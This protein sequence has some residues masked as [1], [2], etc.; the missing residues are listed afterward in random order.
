MGGKEDIF[1]S[2]LSLFWYFEMEADTIETSLLELE[3]ANAMMD[4]SVAN[5]KKLDTS[6]TSYKVEMPLWR[7]DILRDWERR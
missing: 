4:H 2:H 1:M 6:M 3:V 7:L 5:T